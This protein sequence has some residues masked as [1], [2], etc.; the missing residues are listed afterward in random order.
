MII[1]KLLISVT[2]PDG[3][4]SIEVVELVEQSNWI[5]ETKC[6]LVQSMLDCQFCHE[7]S[8]TEFSPFRQPL[9]VQ[10]GPL[11]LLDLGLPVHML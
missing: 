9:V 10:D 1:S 3:A 8:L 2:C 4:S 7:I 5:P 11:P 6:S